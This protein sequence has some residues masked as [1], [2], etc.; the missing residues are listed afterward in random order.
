[1]RRKRLTIELATLAVLA[2]MVFSPGN[3]AEAI[4]KFSLRMLWLLALKS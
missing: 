4:G 3:A 2:I 1:M